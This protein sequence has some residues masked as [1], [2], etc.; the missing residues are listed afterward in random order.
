MKRLTPTLSLL[1]LAGCPSANQV[2]GDEPMGRFKLQA[3]LFSSDCQLSDVPDGG[4]AFDAEL[5]RNRGTSQAWL[6]IG[7]IAR[8]AGFDG[9]VATSTHSAPRRFEEC[10]CGDQTL[11]QETLTVALLSSSQDRALGGACPPSPLDGG[12]PRPDPDGGIFAP[13]SLEQGGFDAIRACGELVD[14]VVPAE[15]ASCSCPRCTMVF[16]VEGTR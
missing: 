8:D 5:S 3:S 10:G 15:G 6:V 12:V 1:F 16:R 2:L 14:E 9:Q 4:F 11:I 7:G 13:A